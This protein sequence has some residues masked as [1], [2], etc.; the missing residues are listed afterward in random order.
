MQHRSLLYGWVNGPL[1]NGLIS[2]VGLHIKTFMLR[3]HALLKFIE[4]KCGQHNCSILLPQESE[5]YSLVATT[6][7]GRI[8][9]SSESSML[10]TSGTTP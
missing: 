10:R 4:K 5:S 1:L 9:L 8:T 6:T 2:N 3:T 7:S